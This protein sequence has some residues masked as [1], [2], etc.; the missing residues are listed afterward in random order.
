MSSLSP[1]GALGQVLGT[2]I[3]VGAA[4]ALVPPAQELANE[5]WRRFPDRPLDPLTLAQ[6]V[7]QGQ[8]DAGWAQDEALNMG[9]NAAR[10]NRLVAVFDTGPGV[11]YAFDLWRRG[12]I[13]ETAFRRAL[14]REGLEEEWIDALTELHNVL[15]SSDELAMMQQQGFIDAARAN[16]EAALQ[17]VTAERQQLRFQVSGLPPGIEMALAMLRRGIID[18]A[19]FSQIVREGHT[20]TKY[21]DEILAL[22]T[23]VLSAAEYASA[24]LR[25]WVTEDEAAAGGAKSG[26]TPEDMELLFL[27][28]GRPASPTQ[29]W[30]AWARGVIGPRGVPTTYEDHAKAIA[31]SDIRPEYAELLWG[32]R[33]NYPSLFALRTAVQSGGIS[34]ERAKTIL[35]FQRYEEQDAESVVA[36][37]VSGT[38][39]ASKSLT[40]AQL[41]IEYEAHRVTE[42][43]YRQSLAALGYDAHEVDL[44]VALGEASVVAAQ[45]DAMVTALKTLYLKHK[46]DDGQVATDLGELG[47]SNAGIAVILPE[48]R[49]VRDA[50]RTRLTR[51]EIK[52]AFKKAILTREQAIADLEA[53][54][55][56][57]EEA[58]TYLD[59]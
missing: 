22:R 2:G 5:A 33:H 51:S 52:A 16:E 41:A 27:N 25:E 43:E 37:W 12:K 56:T 7:A 48:W 38:K 29:M 30:T 59:T 26:Y 10:W 8:I 46:I 57:A 14:K 36:S 54:G 24:R 21:T 1:L 13:G 4:N 23:Q 58:A 19:E 6:G 42:T 17:G 55:L 53:L 20:K 50:E 31:I 32:I 28:R 40:Q 34:P 49:L 44:L 39:L 35:H 15:L 11:G 9:V 18:S 47:I 45:R 3:G